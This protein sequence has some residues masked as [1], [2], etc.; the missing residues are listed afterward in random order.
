MTPAPGE[1]TVPMIESDHNN[2]TPDKQHAWLK[3]S[4]KVLAT[5]VHGGRFIPDEAL[6]RPGRGARSGARQH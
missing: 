5:I 1:A 6:T 4:E 3:R 2:I